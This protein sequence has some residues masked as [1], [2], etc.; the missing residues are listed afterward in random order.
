MSEKEHRARAAG[1]AVVAIVT[2]SDTRDA[3]TDASGNAI[4]DALAAA[5]HE[6]LGPRILR[7]DAAALESEL[8]AIVR[9]EGVDAVIVNGGTGVA[10]RDHAYDILQR[11]YDKPMPGFGEF[12]RALSYKK[13]G[14]AALLSRASAGVAGGKIVFSLPGSLGAVR[15][16]L[17]KLILPEIGHILGELRREAP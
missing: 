6:V 17:D 14:S 4:R 1:H 12:F 16:A 11:L 3:T 10:P 2:L 15:L 13:I 9:A 5:G 7:E 8:R